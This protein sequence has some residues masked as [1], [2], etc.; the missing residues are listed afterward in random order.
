MILNNK[1]LFFF[2]IISLLVTF[3]V[4]TSI[5]WQG[6]ESS[7]PGGNV[8]PPINPGEES[9]YKDGPLSIGGVLE[10]MEEEAATQK[11]VLNLECI[12]D[13]HCQ[14]CGSWSSWYCDGDDRERE[15]T[16]YECQGGDC[17]SYS[18]YDTQ[19]CPDRCHE[20]S[21]VECVTNNDCPDCGSWSSWY[22]D[23]DDRVRE[24]TCYQCQNNNCTSYTDEQRE[25][26]PSGCHNGSCLAGECTPGETE[27]CSRT[28][29]YRCCINERCDTCTRTNS[30]EKTCRSD[31]TWGSCDASAPTCPSDQCR[32]N[33][34]CEDDPDPPGDGCTDQGG[35]WDCISYQCHCCDGHDCAPVG[36]SCISPGDCP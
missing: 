36:G 11:W 30:G 12:R 25:N 33:S 21:C 19:S 35:Y 9:Q 24:R 16:C 20:G 27:S 5:N 3:S 23:G 17:V 2:I 14:D 22:C 1:K 15:R 6:P 7:P 32:F 13:D 4:V 26:C 8:P 31:G 34:D 29:S 28:C 10:I 18:E